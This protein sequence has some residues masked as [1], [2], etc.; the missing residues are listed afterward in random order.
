MSISIKYL[1]SA[2][3]CYFVSWGGKNYTVFIN[4][5][6]ITAVKNKAGETFN[7]Y[8]LQFKNSVLNYH[9]IYN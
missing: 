8:P 4:R 9:A 7:R 1:S 6:G 3:S 5:T 2:E